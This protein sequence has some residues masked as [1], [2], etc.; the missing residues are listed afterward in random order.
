MPHPVADTMDVAGVR[1]LF[2]VLG[3][4]ETARMVRCMSVADDQTIPCLRKGAEAR[5]GGRHTRLDSHVSVGHHL[6]DRSIWWLENGVL[7]GPD[8]AGMPETLTAA[9]PGRPVTEFMSHPCLDDSMTIM[10]VDRDPLMILT[11]ANTRRDLREMERTLT[12]GI[13]P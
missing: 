4:D 3:A 12:K 5:A 6:D 2:D 9:M 1:A 10:S 8:A 13:R 11:L 7:T